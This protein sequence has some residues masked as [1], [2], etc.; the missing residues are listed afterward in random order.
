MTK[1]PDAGCNFCVQLIQELHH[2]LPYDHQDL[3]RTP[4]RLHI[5]RRFSGGN[6]EREK[7]LF[8]TFSIDLLNPEKECDVNEAGP[9]PFSMVSAY[10]L[11][12]VGCTRYYC[13]HI[14]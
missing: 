5:I 3:H 13:G 6:N 11:R 2:H 12:Y 7:G 9:P 1:D 8:N 4:L 14:C 10:T